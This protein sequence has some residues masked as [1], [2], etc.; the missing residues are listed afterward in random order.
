MIAK[1]DSTSRGGNGV[2]LKDYL[3]N[4]TNNDRD[5][6]DKRVT[7]YG[8]IDILQSCI[9]IGHDKG[10]KETYRNIVVSFAENYVKN[11]DLKDIALKYISQYVKGYKSDEVVAYAE[12][13]IPKILYKTKI[14]RITGESEKVR[15]KPHIHISFAM[16]SPKLNK[17]LMLNSNDKR[18]YDINLLTR[19]IELDYGFKQVELKSIAKD[20]T[21][22]KSTSKKLNNRRDIK[23][24]IDKYIHENIKY[25]N[26]FKVFKEKLINNFEIEIVRESTVKAKTKSIT[27]LY[28]NKKIRLKGNLFN[29]ST[30]NDAKKQLMNTDKSSIEVNYKLNEQKRLDKINIDLDQFNTAKSEY[31]E[32]HNKY[33]RDKAKERFIEPMEVPVTVKTINY[34]S[35]QAKIYKA[36]YGANID[37]DLKGF[38]IKK[39]DNSPN[40]ITVISNKSKN[41]KVVDRGSEITVEGYNLKEEVTISLE[42]AIAKGWKLEN[43]LSSGSD[44]FIAESKRQIHKLLNKKEHTICND[45]IINSIVKTHSVIKY[46]FYSKYSKESISI[47]KKKP[48]QIFRKTNLN[49]N[50]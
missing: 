18:I 11:D 30:F 26:S 12:V 37:Y 47:T 32:L 10:Y 29:S 15:R 31:I 7:L 34:I 45:K 40:P 38:Y 33:A 25:I 46:N 24:H 27:I 9:K 49:R 36:V 14:N 3:E 20:I 19:K 4:G 2:G 23:A 6:K 22:V 16:Y 21:Q 41:I 17:Q 1:F 48:I 44:V 43:I 5:E 42:M 35:Y 39:F 50:K 8:D 13:H 28:K